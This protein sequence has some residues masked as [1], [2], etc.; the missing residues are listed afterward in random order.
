LIETERL[1]LRPPEDGDVDA[2]Y[3]FISD[4]EV[5]RWI[6]PT[7]ATYGYDS[8][9]ERLA[10]YREAWEIDGFGHLMIVD[11]ATGEAVGRVGMLWWDPRTWTFGLRRDIGD[12]GE[13]EIGWTLERAAW[14][15]GYATEAATA[16]RDWML[17]EL[18]PRRLISL[19]HPENVP[20]KRVAERIG[21]EYRHDIVIGAGLTLGLWQLRDD[22]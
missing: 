17:R 7:G 16:T 22:V 15:N 3:R 1:L 14:G 21:E 12:D 8:A 9:K 18:K 5:M 2:V 20:S 10:K 6:D 19:I 4:P 11:R 13:L